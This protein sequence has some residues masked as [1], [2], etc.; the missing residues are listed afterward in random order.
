MD[1]PSL[2]PQIALQLMAYATAFDSGDYDGLV[3]VDVDEAERPADLGSAI[4]RDTFA[5]GMLAARPADLGLALA[6]DT[7]A[8]GNE[9]DAKGL[10]REKYVRQRKHGR[11]GHTTRY[12]IPCNGKTNVIEQ[13]GQRISSELH[14]AL[15]FGEFS[16]PEAAHVLGGSCVV[17]TGSK[18]LGGVT[19]CTVE[20]PIFTEEVVADMTLSAIISIQPDNV[21]VCIANL[22]GSLIGEFHFL[23]DATVSDLENTIQKNLKP[24]WVDASFLSDDGSN[25]RKT[26][27]LKTHSRLCALGRRVT[28]VECGRNT[29][30]VHQTRGRAPTRVLQG[31]GAEFRDY[32]PTWTHGKVIWEAEMKKKLQHQEIHEGVT[33]FHQVDFIGDD[34][35]EAAQSVP[36]GER[37][38][39]LVTLEDYLQMHPDLRMNVQAGS[40]CA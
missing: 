19:K 21:N 18:K 27:N 37:G 14:H 39:R 4:A 26:D 20:V 22:A 16:A 11:G 5:F 40:S 13:D 29:F 33:L 28:E 10:A 9:L 23:M 8:F 36:D 24:K 15:R 2:E 35:C 30:V 3:V 34:V 25:V 38:P 7:F 17:E 12:A 31:C 32:S 1:Q 6:R